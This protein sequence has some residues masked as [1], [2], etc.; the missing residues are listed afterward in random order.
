MGSD[1]NFL[2][3]D[4]ESLLLLSTVSCYIRVHVTLLLPKEGDE[5]EITSLAEI[6]KAGRDRGDQAVQ[7]A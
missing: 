2:I 1:Q 3:S 4:F 6:Y 7:V 5:T